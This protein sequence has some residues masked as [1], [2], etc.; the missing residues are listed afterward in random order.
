MTQ[1]V[2]L[3]DDFQRTL[4]DYTM[5]ADHLPSEIVRFRQANKVVVYGESLAPLRDDGYA[6][7][8]SLTDTW[9]ER[10]PIT[11]GVRRADRRFARTLSKRER[12]QTGPGKGP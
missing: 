6:F 2:V 5:P 10:E 4:K 11:F 7:G 12:H 3:P 1:E 9:I 8:H